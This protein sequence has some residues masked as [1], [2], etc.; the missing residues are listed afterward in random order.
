MI[1]CDGVE[2][3]AKKEPVLTFELKKLADKLHYVWKGYARH[4]A[5]CSGLEL[6][7]E[8]CSVISVKIIP[9]GVK[10]SKEQS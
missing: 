8:K 6:K 2:F 5:S 4:S 3:I 1:I 10:C 7:S 9:K